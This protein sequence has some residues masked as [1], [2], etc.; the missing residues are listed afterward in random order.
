MNGLN[1]LPTLRK[2]LGTNELHPKSW[3]CYLKFLRL[4]STA[5][6]RPRHYDIHPGAAMRTHLALRHASYGQSPFSY[7]TLHDRHQIPYHMD[8]QTAGTS[9]SNGTL[10]LVND[11]IPSLFRFQFS[12]FSD[13]VVN[14]LEAPFNVTKSFALSCSGFIFARSCS[15]MASL[16]SS[17][18]FTMSRKACMNCQASQAA[19]FDS[20]YTVFG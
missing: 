1:G 2:P 20:F 14:Q 17:L 6:V 5:V 16:C 15:K 10:N 8:I 9:V 13:G 12:N 18:A 19:A 3:Y 7:A 11:R 4:V